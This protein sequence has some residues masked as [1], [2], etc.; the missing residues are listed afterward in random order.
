M[1]TNLPWI[2]AGN[3]QCFSFSASGWGSEHISISL[4]KLWSGQVGVVYNTEDL[5]FVFLLGLPAGPLVLRIQLFLHNAWTSS[6]FRLNIINYNIQTCLYF[7][8]KNLPC[9]WNSLWIRFTHL[10]VTVFILKHEKCFLFCGVARWLLAIT[11]GLDIAWRNY[12]QIT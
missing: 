3:L 6:C 1:N 10:L 5:K 9:N 11:T 2:W 7:G 8:N 4:I 12:L